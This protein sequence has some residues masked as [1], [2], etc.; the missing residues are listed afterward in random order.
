MASR[1]FALD[2]AGMITVVKRRGARSIRIG[3]A[4]NGMVRVTQPA[5]MPYAQGV[6]FA[7]EQQAWIAEHR[8]DA[9]LIE[10][11]MQIGKAHHIQFEHGDGHAVTTRITGN[12]ARVIMPIG[13]LAGSSVAQ[14]A[15]RT[16]AVRVL[17]KE[18]TQL[19]PRRLQT[20]AAQHGY[21]YER[22]S[23]KQLRARW[24]SCTA[25]KHIVLNCFL[26]QLPWH[27]IDYVLLHELAHTRVMAHDQSFWSIM[28]HDLPQ[29]RMLKQQIK[30]YKPVL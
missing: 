14:T 24:G 29:V 2:E 20:L 4:H 9:T 22:V 15:A 12:R 19:L 28:E 3:I 11:G 17:K 21:T 27:L 8:P 7:R 30:A 23:I 1:Q 26:M 13:L 18:A 6:Q 10:H 16:V 25:D 5:W